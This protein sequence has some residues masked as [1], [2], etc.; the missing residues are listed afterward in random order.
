MTK[1][2]WCRDCANAAPITDLGGLEDNSFLLIR[3]RA[4][5]A[6]RAYNF[7][8]VNEDKAYSSSFLRQCPHFNNKLCTKDL[9]TKPSKYNF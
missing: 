7:C 8:R 5:K 6:T 3:A 2:V 4:I 1:Q 9:T